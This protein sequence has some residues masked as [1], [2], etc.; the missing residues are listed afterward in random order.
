MHFKDNASFVIQTL[1]KYRY[2]P[3]AI[4]MSEECFA[5]LMLSMED[6]DVSSFSLQYALDWCREEVTRYKR[7]QYENAILRL[8]DVYDC[9]RVRAN[10]LVIYQ[11]P[12]ES[13][14]KLIDSYLSDI[15]DEGRYTQMHLENI[16]HSVTQ[17]CCFAEYNGVCRVE[18]IDYDILEQYDQFMRESSK[19]FYINEGLVSGFLK[20]LADRN[21]CRRGCGIFM[22]YIESGKCTSLKDL[23]PRAANAIEDRRE[24]SGCFP[25]DE[26]YETIFDFTERAVSA[27]YSKTVTDSL[28]Y[29]LTIL[30]LFLDREGLGYDRG[31][32]ETWFSETG[33][34]LFGR[35]ILM[36]R[37]TYEMYDDYTREGDILPL[38]WWKHTETG[39]DRL[40]SWCKGEADAFVSCKQKEGWGKSTIGMYRICVTR[41]LQH[42]DGA[43]IRSFIGLCPEVIKD[44]NLRDRHKTPEAKNAYNSR[45]RKFIIYLE[46]KGIVHAGMHFALPCSSASGEKLVETLSEGDISAIQRYCSSASS[47]LA[48]RD[49]AILLIALDTGL[50]SGDI[51]GM[52]LSS[53]GWKEK[54]VRVIQQKTGVERVFPME[55]ATCNAIYRYLRDAR[56][57]GTGHDALFL[58]IKA[59]YGPVDHS[60]CRCALLRA[61]A[62][63]GS[64]H[65]ARKTFGSLTLNSGSS[66]EETAMMLGHSGT[67]NVH[68]YVSLDSGRLRLCPLSLCETGLSIKGRYGRHE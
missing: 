63:S 60:A 43:G 3:R 50:R 28:P 13:C 32:V 39:F 33:L 25:A 58:G 9:G 62:S 68:K 51:I 21:V 42:L 10:R 14:R 56:R 11:N 37:R 24:D 26:F 44:F 20:Y 65:R 34:R 67:S 53:I 49:A 16:R 4:M 64:I 55:T 12:S 61:G 54:C 48:L 38:H 30:Y 18:D 29:H 19:A 23:T 66:V 2:G 7:P 47:P 17:F 46:L 41:F 31:I 45:I 5:S 57:R 22:H 8:A 15:S 35:G 1:K 52:K 36:A 27:G 59:P 6:K 40:P